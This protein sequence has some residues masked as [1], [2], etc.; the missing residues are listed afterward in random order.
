[1]KKFLSLLAAVALL[2]TGLLGVMPLTASAEEVVLLE[3]DYT[4][5]SGA[6]A[7]ENMLTTFPN[8]YDCNNVRVLS[9]YGRYVCATGGASTC[10]MVYELN[11][12]EGT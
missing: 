3:E 11:I 6:V 4:T 10:S 12:P 1:M 9:Q 2:A 8:L 5:P 7:K